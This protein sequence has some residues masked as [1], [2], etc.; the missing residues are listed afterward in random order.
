[1]ITSKFTISSDD[2]YTCK[3]TK[4]Y[5][6]KVTIATIN[7][8]VGFAAIESLNDLEE[9][10]INYINEL[11]K[12]KDIIEYTVTHKS[13]LVYWTKGIHKLDYPSIYETILESGSMSLMPVIIQKGVQ[14]HKILSP[15]SKEFSNLQKLLKERFSEVIINYIYSKPAELQKSLLT[16]KQREAFYLAFKKGYY[17]IPRKIEAKKLAKKIRINH[18]SYLERLR[19]AEL[20]ILN[21]YIQKK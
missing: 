21:D 13:P 11:R 7:L 18:V 8:P 3:M 20:R 16:K 9:E 4:K 1:M 19:R 10:I 6:V 2:Y 12:T 14:H 15:S 5:N 17:E